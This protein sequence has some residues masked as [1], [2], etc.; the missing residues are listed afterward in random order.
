M[1]KGKIIVNGH[2]YLFSQGDILFAFPRDVHTINTLD[3]EPLEYVVIKLDP[4]ILFD[5][6][7]DAFMFKHF[8]QLIAPVPPELQLIQDLQG[9]DHEKLQTIHDLFLHRP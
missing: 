1:G 8:R 3:S 5:V 9:F 4:D 2:T 7:K 6:P